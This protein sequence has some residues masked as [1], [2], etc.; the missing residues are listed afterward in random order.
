MASCRCCIERQHFPERF[1]LRDVRV[2]PVSG[3]YSGVERT[4]GIGQPL[5]AGIVQVGQGPSRGSRYRAPPLAE[6]DVRA[7]AHPVP[8]LAGSH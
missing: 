4:V 3:R 7:L 1:F 5:R 6:P 8:L 2:P